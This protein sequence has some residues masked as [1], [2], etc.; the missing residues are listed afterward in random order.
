MKKLLLILCLLI[1]QSAFSAGWYFFAPSVGYYQGHYNTNKINGL[2]FN[3]KLG[4]N[5]GKAFIGADVDYATGLNMSDVSYDLN[6]QN[7]SLI[8]GFS[9]KGFRAWYGMVSTANNTYTDGTTEYAATGAGTKIGL[10]TSIGTTYMNLE[11]SFIQY[12]ELSTDGTASTVD[13]FMDVVL[14]SFGWYL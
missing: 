8:L 9:G 3:I 2:G 13:Y 1:S 4:V 7:T 5:W 14:L 6:V 11:A 10:G 12:D